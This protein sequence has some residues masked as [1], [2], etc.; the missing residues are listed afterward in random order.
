MWHYDVR[1]LGDIPELGNVSKIPMKMDMIEL[2]IGY[3][4]QRFW[5]KTFWIPTFTEYFVYRYIIYFKDGKTR[6]TQRGL[7]KI[8]CF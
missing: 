1:V 8:L 4:M 7:V 2:S 3:N 5:E 6:L